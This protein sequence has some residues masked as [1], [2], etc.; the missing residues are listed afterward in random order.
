M[1]DSLSLFT[2]TFVNAPRATMKHNAY[3]ETD[4]LGLLLE[5]MHIFNYNIYYIY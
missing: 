3:N 5:C 1:T 2:H 4:L